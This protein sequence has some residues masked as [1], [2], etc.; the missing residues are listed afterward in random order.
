[1]MEE[2]GVFFPNIVNRRKYKPKQN[3]QQLLLLTSCIWTFA[4]RLIAESCG[5]DEFGCVS[6]SGEYDCLPGYWKC[7]GIED[8]EDGSDE[9]CTAE[10]MYHAPLPHKFY[11]V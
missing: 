2:G 3:I 1:M 9:G 8:C 10:G 11:Q 6:Y 7:D 4:A 5:A